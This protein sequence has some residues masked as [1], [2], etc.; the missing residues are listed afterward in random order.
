[1]VH[2]VQLCEEVVNFIS[3]CTTPSI[4]SAVSEIQ[5]W[6]WKIVSNK[7]LYEE[8][9]GRGGLG[10]GGGGT[11]A[12]SWVGGKLPLFPPLLPLPPPK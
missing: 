3:C 2:S 4:S 6:S 8:V 12:F 5:T 7:K 9:G 1:M 10:G 11:E